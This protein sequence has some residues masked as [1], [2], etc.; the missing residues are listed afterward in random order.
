MDLL[1]P[2]RDLRLAKAISELSLQ[3]RQPSSSPNL[4]RDY[5]GT[6]IQP[7]LY[8][9]QSLGYTALFGLSPPLQFV[10]LP[11][12]LPALPNSAH[13]ASASAGDFV[14]LQ[15]HRDEMT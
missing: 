1:L 2:L 9:R 5:M 3:P 15:L 7:Y 10:R 4:V 13:R 6:Y 8:T 11:V 12:C 14:V